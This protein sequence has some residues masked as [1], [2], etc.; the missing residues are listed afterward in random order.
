PSDKESKMF[1]IYPNPANGD[2]LKLE[3]R[4]LEA[5]REDGIRV[6]LILPNGVIQDIS[7]V[8]IN[9]LSENILRNMK[10]ASKGMYILVIALGGEIEYHKIIYR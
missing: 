3:S 7:G 9:L 5:L 8:N 10:I 2:Q 6:K 4:N 1:S